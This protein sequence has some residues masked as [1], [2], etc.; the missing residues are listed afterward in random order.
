MTPASWMRK[1][2][3][4]HKAYKGDSVVSEEIAHDLMM[5]CKDFGEGKLHIP[6]LL[7]NVKIDL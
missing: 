5:A 3:R 4:E 7:G 2:V 6:E 1:F